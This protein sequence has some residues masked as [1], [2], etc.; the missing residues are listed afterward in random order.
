MNMSSPGHSDGKQAIGHSLAEVCVDLFAT[1]LHIPKSLSSFL[2]IFSD[3]T[4][5]P[6]GKGKMP[7]AHL[8][9]YIHV[10]SF[11]VLCNIINSFLNDEIEMLTVVSLQLYM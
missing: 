1:E 2:I 6:D 11:A 10:F 4:I 8:Q 7:V 5:V 3:H 9:V